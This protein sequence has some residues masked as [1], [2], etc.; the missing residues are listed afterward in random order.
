MIVNA[1]SRVVHRFRRGAR[2]DGSLFNALLPGGN[3]KKGNAPAGDGSL[4]VSSDPQRAISRIAASLRLKEKVQAGTQGS[5][6]PTC[7]R[8]AR[9]VPL[10]MTL[11]CLALF[12]RSLAAQIPQNETTY[13]LH[14]VVLDA[15]TGK[16]IGQALVTS[17]DHRLATLTDSKGQF[18]FE[19]AIPS[20]SPFSQTTA[21]VNLQTNIFLSAERPG[22]SH[23][24][25]QS[26][27]LDGTLSTQTELRLIPGASIAGRVYAS[28]T[29]SPRNV[30]VTL[31]ER[32]IQNG[33]FTW[34]PGNN[35][36]TDRFGAFHFSNL[37]PGEYMV[38]T[39]EWRGEAPLPV[40]KISPTTQYPPVFLGGAS[41]FESAT[42]LV[43]HA[44][45]AA[46]AELH[47]HS[48]T[49]YPVSIP[50]NGQP[51]GLNVVIGSR[52]TSGYNLGYVPRDNAIEGSLPNGAYDL[53]IVSQAAPDGVSSAEF[54]LHVAGALLRTAT[55]TLVPAGNVNVRVD[56]ELTSSSALP[57]VGLSLQ[58]QSDDVFGS[59]SS[60]FIQ[61][62][63]TE[64]TLKGVRPGRYA[65]LPLPTYGYVARISSGGVDL[66][67]HPLT[68]DSSGN[69]QPID[70]TIRDDVATLSG[71]LQI[72]DDVPS[73]RFAVLLLAEHSD[74]PVQTAFVSG[75]RVFRFPNIPPGT[76]RLLALS[77]FKR[78]LPYRDPEAML[79][80][81]KKGKLITLTS[82]EE[83]TADAP[84][85]TPPDGAGAAIGR[86]ATQ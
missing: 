30:Q 86:G 1:L 59:S 47:L 3:G 10:T 75:D 16:G 36:S 6:M 26:I 45:E 80:W 13:K 40:D 56:R 39:Q 48:A 64:S 11:L 53:H 70:V 23:M 2:H 41:S 24:D 17:M 9:E 71:K 72:G 43:L 15:V 38:M 51:S 28:G 29:D 78:E 46:N 32:V 73:D 7:I 82:G 22:Y 8:I 66:M 68:V 19:M 34:R 79:P 49:Y 37:A 58:L 69:V 84:F 25:P 35:H 44:G 31:L 76:Y 21:S 4:M 12:T 77:S 65:V 62:G 81:L 5:L 63:E 55:I 18:S 42:P 50:L 74:R 14:G 57:Q 85:V 61:P 60:G 52:F 27:E 83:A 20:G 67:E 33:L 54:T